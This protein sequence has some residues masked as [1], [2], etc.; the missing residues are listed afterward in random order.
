MPDPRTLNGHPEAFQWS[1]REK[2][3]LMMMIR[4]MSNIICALNV[5]GL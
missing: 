5:H 1:V 3:R 4:P 2:K